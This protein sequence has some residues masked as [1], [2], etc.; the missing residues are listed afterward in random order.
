MTKKNTPIQK[1]NSAVVRA[2]ASE[3]T[4]EIQQVTL[5]G[6]IGKLST[7][8]LGN[9]NRLV[10][11]GKLEYYTKS[12][13]STQ[14]EHNT[15][16]ELEIWDDVAVNALKSV[17]QGDTVRVTGELFQRRWTEQENGE[18]VQRSMHRINVSAFQ[19]LKKAVPKKGKY[20]EYAT[21]SK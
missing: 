19:I 5:V 9:D 16:I 18:D 12:A 6:T 1:T 10:T 3:Q 8:T 11:R 17:S 20:E 14:R 13:V 21:A 7:K 4:H 2:P 15:R